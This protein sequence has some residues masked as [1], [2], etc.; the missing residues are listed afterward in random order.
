M[1]KFKNLH[2]W[3]ILP[4]LVTFFGFYFSYWSVF[5]EAPFY[6]HVHGLTATLWFLLI[7]V[8][9][10]LYQ[11]AQMNL[12]RSLGIIGLFLAGGVVFSALQIIPNNLNL[13]LSDLSLRY[14][15]ILIDFV[16]LI[17]FAYAVIQSVLNKKDIEL[18]A[19]YIISTVFWIMLPA[20]TRLLFFPQM[21]IFGHPTPL[22]FKECIYA[23]GII[24]LLVLVILILLD[25]KKIKS[26]FVLIYQ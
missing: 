2:F 24:V 16:S 26:F 11:K 25:Y 3:L 15:F 13:K 14:I 19:R 8:Q 17:G 21:V 23:A 9:P 6:Q 18:H 4:F 5:N 7:I 12:H 10:F 1:K 20:L 22:S